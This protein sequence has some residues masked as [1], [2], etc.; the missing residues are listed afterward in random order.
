[1]KNNKIK[2]IIF[3]VV[4]I[5][6]CVLVFGA[7]SLIKNKT[8]ALSN[9]ES[10]LISTSSLV[11]GSA[12]STVFSTNTNEQFLITLT[13]GG[14]TNHIVNVASQGFDPYDINDPYKL[15]VRAY[16]KN[17]TYFIDPSNGYLFIFF[18]TINKEINI[19]QAFYD[20][21]S[22][23]RISND[24]LITKFSISYEISNNS[25]DTIT[26]SLLYK[27]SNNVGQSAF[28]IGTINTYWL[29]SWSINPYEGLLYQSA[30]NRFYGET[31]DTAYAAGYAAGQE[32]ET[33]VE[34]VFNLLTHI[35]SIIGAIWQIELVPH[36]P[37]GLFILVPIFFA[38]VGLVLW[39][40]RRN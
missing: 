13:G 15:I 16:A 12:D 6:I 40:W 32:G 37:L 4:L 11:W 3:F 34:P 20:T 31:W 38:I 35:F 27:G 2:K 9:S 30:Y 10:Y 33:S 1:M 19:Y 17:E 23:L 26:Y 21:D 24:T 18:D 28:A 29:G 39:I 14:L 22:K 5:I 8:K 25:Y 7:C 36:V